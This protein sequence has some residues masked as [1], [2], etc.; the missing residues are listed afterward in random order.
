[1]AHCKQGMVHSGKLRTF[2]VHLMQ[3]TSCL[4]LRKFCI[5]IILNPKTMMMQTMIVTSYNCAPT[6]G[7]H[8]QQDLSQGLGNSKISSDME[9]MS[10]MSFLVCHW[11]M[12]LYVLS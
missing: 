12:E 1:M 3:I 7:F 11:W 5:K 2:L 8:V 6:R 9:Q 4:E 10:F